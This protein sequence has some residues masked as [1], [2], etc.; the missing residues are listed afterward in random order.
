MVPRPFEKNL[1]R[2]QNYRDGSGDGGDCRGAPWASFN[3]LL[4]IKKN[5]ISH[6]VEKIYQIR[7]WVNIKKSLQDSS[8]LV[9]YRSTPNLPYFPSIYSFILCSLIS[10][11]LTNL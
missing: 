7:W 9:P 8:K 10:E 5:Y 1:K 2:K 6:G 4:K 11:G 3:K